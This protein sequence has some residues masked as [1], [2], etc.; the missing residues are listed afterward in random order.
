MSDDR[1]LFA[2]RLTVR[3][4]DCD[5][6]GHVNHAVYLTYF[7]QCRFAWWTHLGGTMGFPGA[8]TVIVHAEA[9]YRAPAFLNDELEIRL[10]PGAVGRSSV[11]L[12]YEIVNV[13]TGQRLAEGKTVNVTIDPQTH[14]TIPVPEATRKRL[15]QRG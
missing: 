9:D 2:H 6:M 3:F 5:L 1:L 11:V 12:T 8:S 7:E 15:A 10:T 14:A 4:R 13:A